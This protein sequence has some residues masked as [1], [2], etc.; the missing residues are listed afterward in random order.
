MCRVQESQ[1]EMLKCESPAS[2]T[3]FTPPGPRQRKKPSP[4]P[5]VYVSLLESPEQATVV[6]PT[7]ILRLETWDVGAD[8]VGSS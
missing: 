2:N 7:E 5:R 6:V 4:E 8:V 1:Q 3:A